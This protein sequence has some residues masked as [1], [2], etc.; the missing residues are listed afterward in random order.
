ML[1]KKLMAAI[2]VFSFILILTLVFGFAV[3]KSENPENRVKLEVISGNPEAL[4]DF[5]LDVDFVYYTTNYDYYEDN[6][7]IVCTE[8]NRITYENGL[9]S[10][11]DYSLEEKGSIYT[12]GM[13]CEFEPD[14]PQ[15]YTEGVHTVKSEELTIDLRVVDDS[16]GW[17]YIV[18]DYITAAPGTEFT[19]IYEK[20][21]YGWGTEWI[22]GDE[23]GG[24]AE[25]KSQPGT[26]IVD[27]Y[28]DVEWNPYYINREYIEFENPE[29]N[30]IMNLTLGPLDLELTTRKGIYEISDVE[31][32][33]VDLWEVPKEHV[34]K[35]WYYNR[36]SQTASYFTKDDAVITCYYKNCVTGEQLEKVI[37]DETDAVESG[38]LDVY[39]IAYDGWTWCDDEIVLV[40]ALF[41]KPPYYNHLI[42]VDVKTGEIL[43]YHKLENNIGFNGF[44]QYSA[45]RLCVCSLKYAGV[46]PLVEVWIFE[47]DKL[48]FNGR[49]H[50]DNEYKMPLERYY[51]SQK[52]IKKVAVRDYEEDWNLG[53]N[54]VI[55]ER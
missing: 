53:V 21:E 15:R 39:G 33:C 16:N 1:K 7:K 41:S 30:K 35:N 44:L 40:S 24:S 13:R 34:L 45:G 38:E 8:S 5:Q 17:V 20:D 31:I 47:A 2:M 32:K 22:P 29:Y 43:N 49:L 11:F 23:Y 51:L 42:M 28:L 9:K 50:F 3:S 36:E 25:A 10:K 46:E 52:D 48:I 26:G 6:T 4:S 18:E 27:V 37:I 54:V 55:S 19:Y 14:F 12:E